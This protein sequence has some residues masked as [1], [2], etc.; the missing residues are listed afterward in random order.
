MEFSSEPSQ[1]SAPSEIWNMKPKTGFAKDERRAGAVPRR[2]RATRSVYGKA[3]I[4]NPKLTFDVPRS[5]NVANALTVG[6][7]DSNMS[8]SDI[9]NQEVIHIKITTKF[10]K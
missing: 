1:E 4:K 9:S 5:K 2:H 7:G 8:Q 3:P 10:F 6:R